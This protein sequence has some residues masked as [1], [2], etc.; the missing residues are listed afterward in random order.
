[1][2]S[3]AQALLPIIGL[4]LIKTALLFS[5]LLTSSCAHFGTIINKEEVSKINRVAIIGFS[6]MRTSGE[7]IKF[8][9]LANNK[10][11]PNLKKIENEIFDNLTH[12][13]KVNTGWKV[14]KPSELKASK[15]FLKHYNELHKKTPQVKRPNVSIFN[16]D[17]IMDSDTSRWLTS[18]DLKAISKE[19]NVDAFVF[20][21]ENQ[22]VYNATLP[23]TG[24][25]IQFLGD[26]FNVRSVSSLRVLDSNKKETIIQIQ[27]RYGAKVVN[28]NFNPNLS[29]QD[30]LN[31]QSL[32]SSQSAMSLILSELY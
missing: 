10:S 1:M 18:K 13:I 26:K 21:V 6:I 2:N 28:N 31:I 7:G 19:L 14:L 15:T 32:K 4:R 22:L 24:R 16:V 30:K 27:N 17:G 3:V 11:N 5:F 12:S 9:T 20:F 29:Y 25:K 8:N 23:F